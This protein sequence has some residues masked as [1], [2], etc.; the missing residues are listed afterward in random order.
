VFNCNKAIAEYRRSITQRDKATNKSGRAK[1][2]AAAVQ[3]RQVWKEW[4]GEDSL[5]QIAF[6]E[7]QQ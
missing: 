3:M 2:E 6:G 5:H 4:Q 1:L 7:P